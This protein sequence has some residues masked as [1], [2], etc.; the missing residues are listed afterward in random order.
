MISKIFPC[1]T[2]TILKKKKKITG[3]CW[4]GVDV[5]TEDISD[6][7][8]KCVWEP[9]VVKKNALQA[10][11]EAVCLILSVDETI[12]N[13]KSTSGGGAGDMPVPR[14]PM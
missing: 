14:R 12:K 10:A 11:S 13:P 4:F 5:M 9:A 6:N 3:S 8:E 7:M 1:K 2:L